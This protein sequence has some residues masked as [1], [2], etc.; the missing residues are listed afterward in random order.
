MSMSRLLSLKR[1]RDHVSKPVQVAL[2]QAGRCTVD[3]RAAGSE[4]KYGPRKKYERR[5]GG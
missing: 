1:L 3:M 2:V 5:A 4:P